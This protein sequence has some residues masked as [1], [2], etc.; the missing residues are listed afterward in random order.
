MP[1]GVAGGAIFSGGLVG[2]GAFGSPC[3]AI[4]G[5]IAGAG[6]RAGGA[7]LGGVAGAVSAAGA[8]PAFIAAATV[9]NAASNAT[10]NG[11]MPR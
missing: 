3:E 7:T 2:T 6:G 1:L 8:G 11:F 10:V 5:G 9:P 4:G